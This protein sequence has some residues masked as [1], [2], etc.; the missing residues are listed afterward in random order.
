[1]I[2]KEYYK[3]E[4]EV[5][6]STRVRAKNNLHVLNSQIILKMTIQC[7]WKKWMGYRVAEREKHKAW[8]SGIAPPVEAG[9]SD[10]SSCSI[11]PCLSSTKQ[12]GKHSRVEM[13]EW[14]ITK[15]EVR[16]NMFGLWSV[17]R[18]D[19]IRFVKKSFQNAHVQESKEVCTSRQPF[20]VKV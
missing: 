10:T 16:I 1:M 2:V 3:H 7:S 19:L 5:Y 6:L 8:T 13:V 20:S 4:K 17:Y 18:K 11:K 12:R 14:P 15:N 9:F